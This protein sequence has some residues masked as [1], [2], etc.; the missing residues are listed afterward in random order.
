[1]KIKQEVESYWSRSW[2]L[3]VFLLDL[4]QARCKKSCRIKLQMTISYKTWSYVHMP[5]AIDSPAGCSTLPPPSTHSISATATRFKK[6]RYKETSC[7]SRSPSWYRCNT[8]PLIQGFQ[9]GVVCRN[10]GYANTPLRSITQGN[11]DN[12]QCCKKFTSN[13]NATSYS[14]V[15]TVVTLLQVVLQRNSSG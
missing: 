14:I 9:E 5:S 13:A 11:H 1:M 4:S 15:C 10:Y 2:V 6:L 8:A 12:T 3:L 7:N